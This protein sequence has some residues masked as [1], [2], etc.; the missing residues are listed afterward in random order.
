MNIHCLDT[1]VFCGLLGFW[2]KQSNIYLCTL[3]VV[4]HN[5]Q[6]NVNSYLS[7]YVYM[8]NVI[9]MPSYSSDGIVYIFTKDHFDRSTEVQVLRCIALWSFIP[10]RTFETYFLWMSKEIV[11]SMFDKLFVMLIISFVSYKTDNCN[12]QKT[13]KFKLPYFLSWNNSKMLAVQSFMNG[14][15]PICHM[16]HL[17]V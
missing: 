5:S 16:C 1:D 15:M 14:N 10:G 9:H 6:A 2:L 17:T 3:R 11:C 4:E 13:H 7:F 12:P 8:N